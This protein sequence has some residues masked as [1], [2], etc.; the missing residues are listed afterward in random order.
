[1]GLIISTAV[2]LILLVMSPSSQTFRVN[3]DAVRVDVLVTDGSRPV[4]GL[5]PM[6]FELRDSGVLQRLESVF[7]EELPVSMMLA[8]DASSSVRGVPLE[9]L[10]GAGS[11]VVRLLRPGDRGAV[12]TFSE[13][14]DHASGWTSDHQQLTLALERT[15]VS[16]STVL[17]DATYAAL[18]L[19]D[20]QA[21]RLLVIIFS[22]GDDTASWLSGPAVIDVAR[23]T[24]AVVY[25]VG[26]RNVPIRK[27]GYLVDFRSGLPPDIPRVVPS[28]LA[29][30]FLSALA[31]ETGGKYVEIGRSHQLRET[32]ERILTEFRTRYVLT[33]IPTGVGKT[34]WHPIEV[35]LKNKRG[36]VTARRGYM[37]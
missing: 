6:D 9:H 4:T 37:R 10:K 18:T 22:D 25:A 12:L 5:E 29:Q 36:S 32:F 28:A 19:R 27:L 30:S 7:I 2:M 33:Y 24:D 35:R 8:L 13:E 21:G 31:D 11:A 20:P 26:L 15:E 23:H 16:G 14:I 34:G 3:V 1:M 17:H